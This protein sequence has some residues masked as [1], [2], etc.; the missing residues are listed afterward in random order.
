VTTARLVPETLALSSMRTITGA[1][2]A[3]DTNLPHPTTLLA[4]GSTPDSDAS[5]AAP[6]NN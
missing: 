3:R 2:P 4:I 5:R 6:T 1:T